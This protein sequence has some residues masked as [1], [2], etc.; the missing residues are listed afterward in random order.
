MMA[1]AARTPYYEAV[2][3]NHSVGLGSPARK[4]VLFILV[5]CEVF[6]RF[7]YVALTRK[8]MERRW[9]GEVHGH[10][11]RQVS[12]P[13]FSISLA[14]LQCGQVSLSAFQRRLSTPESTCGVRSP[15]R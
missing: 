15:S 13:R 12:I 3:Y 8:S 14:S 5:F 9:I 1:N 2:S 7:L 4:A 11:A 10:R 6:L